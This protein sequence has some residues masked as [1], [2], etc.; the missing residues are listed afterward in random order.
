MT[1]LTGSEKEAKKRGGGA[2]AITAARFGPKEES[3]FV[4]KCPIR[5]AVCTT[6]RSQYKYMFPNPG[7]HYPIVSP[8]KFWM[9]YPI[10]IRIIKFIP[11][12]LI[13]WFSIELLINVIWKQ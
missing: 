10:K 7:N 13:Y 12:L 1:E 6:N 4:Y 3:L 8:S 5:T 9:V 11:R 2:S